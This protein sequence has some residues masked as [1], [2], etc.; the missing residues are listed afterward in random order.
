MAERLVFNYGT[1]RHDGSA[2]AH[3]EEVRPDIEPPRVMAVAR[4]ESAIARPRAPGR[5]WGFIGLMAFT[6]ILFLRP[7]DHVGFLAAFH[8]AEIAAIVGLVA[9][10]AGR[11]RRGQLVTRITPELVGVAALGGIILLTAPFSIWPGGSVATFTDLYAKVLLIFLLMVNTLN[12]PRRVEQ[13][14][15]LI[16]LASGYI[17]FRAVF[18]YARGV[19]LIENGRVQGF[20]SG[21]FRNPNDLALNMVSVLPLGLLMALRG[22]TTPRRLIAAGCC[23]VMLGAIIASH[24]RSG[25]VGLVAMLLFLGVYLLRRRPALVLAGVVMLALALPLTPESYWHRLS[26]ITDGSQDETGSREARRVLM[27]EGYAAFLANPLTGVGAGQFKNYAPEHRVE[28]WRETHNVVLQIAAELGVL[29]LI[30]FT[31][32]L[33]RAAMIGRQMTRLLK[34][35]TAHSVV[36]PAEAQRLDEHKCAIGAALAGWFVCAL[37]ASVAYNWTFYYLLALAIAPREILIDRLPARRS[38]VPA[39]G[40]VAAAVQ[41][42]RA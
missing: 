13:L 7:Q 1:S 6:A 29:G 17:A 15:W 26:S 28:A 3:G 24:S 16:V 34:R 4:S 35:A 42:A 19:N 30:V 41:E 20:V 27:R 36:T 37:F 33:I 9:M 12:T 31:F 32:L 22:R 38:R 5:D 40:R 25:S 10:T 14:V 2:P 8:L 11:L 18:D 21:I 23:L 39:P